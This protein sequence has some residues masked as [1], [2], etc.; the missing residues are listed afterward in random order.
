MRY[1]KPTR[2]ISIQNVIA[3]QV[4]NFLNSES[5]HEFTNSFFNVNILDG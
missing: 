5:V 2:N 4:N 3:F 1:V